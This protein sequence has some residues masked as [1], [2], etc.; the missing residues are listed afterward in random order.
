MNL[1]L[2]RRQ[3]LSLSL[4]VC[5]EDNRLIFAPPIKLPTLSTI[6]ALNLGNLLKHTKQN[7]AEDA[8][9]QITEII[10]SCS[11]NRPK[12]EMSY[13]NSSGQYAGENTTYS[14]TSFKEFLSVVCIF[15]SR[16]YI[17]KNHVQKL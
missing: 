11:I 17:I 8:S 16:T 3:Q 10:T 15:K 6:P 14:N 13:S 1:V 5:N 7:K 2:K 12:V 9:L 4:E